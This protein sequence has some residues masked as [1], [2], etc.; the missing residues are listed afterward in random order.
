MITYNK[1]TFLFGDDLP[2]EFGLKITH[3]ERINS[4]YMKKLK[5][6]VLNKY[7]IVE[8]ISFDTKEDELYPHDVI[9]FRIK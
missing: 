8:R 9:Y 7:K 4:T 5:K 2:K 3:E 6:E 1:E